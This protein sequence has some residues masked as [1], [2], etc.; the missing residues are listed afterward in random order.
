[1][2]KLS[3]ST[4]IAAM[5][6]RDRSV[7]TSS[8][9][10]CSP[11]DSPL[12]DSREAGSLAFSGPV[13]TSFGDGLRAGGAGGGT[14]FDIHG[15][16]ERIDRGVAFAVFQRVVEQRLREAQLGAVFHDSGLDAPQV[17]HRER[18]AEHLHGRS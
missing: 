11:A 5:L 9:K 15:L 10:V 7:R 12:T 6:N 14:G 3:K 18:Q 13:I 2:P 4:A 17:A 8:R 1:M 16:Q